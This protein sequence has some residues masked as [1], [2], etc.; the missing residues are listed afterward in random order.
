MGVVG[1]ITVTFLA[2]LHFHA[3]SSCMHFGRR[4][5]SEPEKSLFARKP[6]Q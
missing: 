3:S 6:Y 2:F 4:A 1:A 5:V